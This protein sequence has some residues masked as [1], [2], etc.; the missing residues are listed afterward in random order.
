ME[1]V[2]AGNSRDLGIERESPSNAKGLGSGTSGRAVGHS[3][4][5]QTLGMENRDTQASSLPVHSQPSVAG[6]NATEKPACCLWHPSEHLQ[7]AE[8][9]SG[10]DLGT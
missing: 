4:E 3:L 9:V 5:K 6:S 7:G 10:L 2:C 8:A 1:R